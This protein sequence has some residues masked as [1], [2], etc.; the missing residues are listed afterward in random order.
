MKRKAKTL[1]QGQRSR[2]ALEFSKRM[3]H[4]GLAIKD[5]ASA[6]HLTY[7]HVRKLVSGQALPSIEA[8][9][10]ISGVLGGNLEEMTALLF[11]EKASRT[12][13]ADAVMKMRGNEELAPI[14]ASWP[15][16]NSEQKAILIDIA[17]GMAT[18]NVG[19]KGSVVDLMF[20]AEGSLVDA[21]FPVKGRL[22]KR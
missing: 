20:P 22:T 8:L 4:R 11:A 21:M 15:H 6:T 1:R 19:G 10:L 9:K 18:R 2:L 17:E 13:G 12:Y 7:E 16:L 14:E 3:E 5:L